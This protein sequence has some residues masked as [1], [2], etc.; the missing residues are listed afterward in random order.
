M[1]K[2]IWEDSHRL[3]SIEV[4]FSRF[5]LDQKVKD[6]QSSTN[7]VGAKILLKGTT[8]PESSRRKSCWESYRM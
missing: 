4:V 2:S 7:Q 3:L 1:V 6:A 8:N 5:R